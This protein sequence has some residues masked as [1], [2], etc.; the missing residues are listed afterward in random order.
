[1]RTVIDSYLLV[2]ESEGRAKSTLYEYNLY[3]TS[4]MTHCGK[5]LGRPMH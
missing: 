4:F 1:M 3:L 2:K 5:P